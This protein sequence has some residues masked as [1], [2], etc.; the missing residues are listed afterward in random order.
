MSFDFLKLF[1]G[2]RTFPNSADHA[3]SEDDHRKN[4]KQKSENYAH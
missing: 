2:A 3:K 1:F 4:E